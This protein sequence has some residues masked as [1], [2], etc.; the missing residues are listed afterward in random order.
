MN[1][2]IR[3]IVGEIKSFR[4]FPG[5]VSRED[6]VYCWVIRL[7]HIFTGSAVGLVIPEAVAIPCAACGATRKTNCRYH[8]ESRVPRGVEPHGD[9]QVA[10]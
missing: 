4:Y 8:A 7:Y 9:L 2:P 3:L 10:G 6:A 1:Q 5:I